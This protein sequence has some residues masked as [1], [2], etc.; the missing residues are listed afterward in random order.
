MGKAYASIKRGLQ[1]AARHR[2]G[3]RVAGLKLHAVPLT[4]PRTAR[5]QDAEILRRL[6]E[7][8]AGTA[9]L[10]DRATMRRRIRKRMRR[11]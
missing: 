8:D 4:E 9:Q 5:E 2:R 11:T 1:Q 6:S 3:K 7:I 10:V